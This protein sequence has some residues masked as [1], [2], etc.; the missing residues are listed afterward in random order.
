MY[1]CLLVVFLIKNSKLTLANE[2]CS[3][4]LSRGVVDYTADLMV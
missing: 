1:I 2:A 3:K 4:F